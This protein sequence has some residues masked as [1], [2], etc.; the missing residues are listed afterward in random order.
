MNLVYVVKR[1]P[2]YSETFVLHE[3]Q[4]LRTQRERVT[5]WSLTIAAP[6]RAAPCADTH[7]A[8]WRPD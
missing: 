4:E 1:F 5:V 2:K 6:G 3:I 7:L 8:D